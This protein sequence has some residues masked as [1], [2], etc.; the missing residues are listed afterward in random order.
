MNN[1]MAE[2]YELKKE[3]YTREGIPFVSYLHESGYQILRLDAVAV[4]KDGIIRNPGETEDA[5]NKRR[6]KILKGPGK[7]TISTQG[8]KQF[9]RIVENL[10]KTGTLIEVVYNGGGGPRG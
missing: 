8:R 6:R 3:R 4:E 1:K 2:E 9:D 5:F 10:R 7:K